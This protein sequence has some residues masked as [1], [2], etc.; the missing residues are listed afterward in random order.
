MNKNRSFLCGLLV[1][2]AMRWIPALVALLMLSGCG[3]VARQITKHAVPGAS[4]SKSKEK[5]TGIE[6]VRQEAEKA[7]ASGAKVNTEEQLGLPYYPGSIK[8]GFSSITM[9]SGSKTTYSIAMATE[10]SVSKVGEFYRAEGAKA[11]KVDS[12]MESLSSINND[13]LQV[14]GVDLNDGRRSQ[15][16]A[17]ASPEGYTIVTVHTIEK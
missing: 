13:K 14:I 10:D 4:S 2:R 6:K 1:S 9:K 16:Q 15:I 12:K 5:L 7:E 8:V 11:G 17:M 3:A